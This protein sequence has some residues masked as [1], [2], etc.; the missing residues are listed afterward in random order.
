[1]E[2]SD[3]AIADERLNT[4]L[5]DAL[6]ALASGLDNQRRPVRITF[7][8]E[9]TRRVKVGYVTEMPIWKTSYRLVFG[10]QDALMQ[11]WAIV[12]NTSDTD[13]Q[14]VRLS[15][16]SGRPVSF[17]QDL[18]SPIYVPRPVYEPARFASLRPVMYSAVLDAA[19]YD[20]NA[21]PR[22]NQRQRVQLR[23]GVE[24]GEMENMLATPPTVN[25]E[26]AGRLRAY[27]DTVQAA[28]SA[29]DLGQ[30]FQYTVKEL[31]TL[32]R[33]QSAM[34]PII[35]EGVGAWKVTISSPS[36]LHPMY[37]MRLKNTTG[38]HLMGGP[39]T[40]YSDDVYA[41]DA[42]VEDL[43]PGEDRLIS[44]AVD[45]GMKVKR[46]DVRE[47]SEIL[48]FK[49]V[50]GMLHIAR[51]YRRTATYIAAIADGKDR[52][53]II[54]HPLQA[55]WELIEPE[56]ADEKTNDLYRFV[57]Q[58]P[59]AE[60]AKLAVV[61]ERKAGET[62][63]ITGMNTD[64]LVGY[65]TTGKM[66]DRVKAA[67]QRVVEMQRRLNELRYQRNLAE[68][69]INAITAEQNRIRSNM[70]ALDRNSDLYKRYVAKL[71][72]QETRIEKLRERIEEL[73]QREGALRKE[74][75]DYVAGLNL[76]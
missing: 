9:G 17:I 72:E 20:S 19:G 21:T 31:V 39:I 5:R 65:I 70:G 62:L 56:K 24:L 74:L 76:D 38:M 22:M 61:E 73:T 52:K 16:V 26:V 75:N 53:L 63:A 50:Q 15:L 23:G 40:V 13:W 32:P 8:G 51:K 67:M 7:A 44:Y 25:G 57:R 42:V 35:A 18:Y 66:S 46:E 45:L 28:A 54:E 58:V 68:Q 43:Q 11:G 12:E 29:K 10:E 55:G 4:E 6:D 64:A 60:G 69:E 30:G 34:L 3:I 27:S 49:V 48:T 71:G 1:E 36:S 33:Q 37:G 14:N 41:G 47:T 59:A 2:I